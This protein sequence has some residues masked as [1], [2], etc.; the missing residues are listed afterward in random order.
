VIRLGDTD[1]LLRETSIANA[2]SGPAGSGDAAGAW[3]RATAVRLPGDDLVWLR[4]A[5]SDPETPS[6]RLRRVALRAQAEL[7]AQRPSPLLPLLLDL[8]DDQ[9]STT[10]VISHP[11]GQPWQEAFGPGSAGLDRAAVTAMLAAAADV[12]ATLGE[13]HRRGHQHRELG[14]SAIVVD[15][16]GRGRLRDLGLLAVPP[17]PSDGEA[18]YRAPEQAQPPYSAGAPTEVFQLAALVLHTL[19]GRPPLTAPIPPLRAILPFFPPLVEGLLKLSVDVDFRHR[20]ADL[21]QVAASFRSGHRRLS[22]L[23]PG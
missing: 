13:L 15:G 21:A 11:G 12:A 1:Y 7:L 14:P 4:Q 20:P 16:D 10:L 8:V 3:L 5:V 2:D 6:G 9:T 18:A 22:R 23:E 17:D 19:T